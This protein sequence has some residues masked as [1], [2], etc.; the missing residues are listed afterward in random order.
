MGDLWSNPSNLLTVATFL[1]G[2]IVTFLVA[3]YSN[4]G[5]QRWVGGSQ[6]SH[7]KAEIIQSLSISLGEGTPLSKPVLLAAIRSV[8]REKQLPISDELDA[9]KVREILDELLYRVTANPF[10]ESNRR[11]NLQKDLLERMAEFDREGA[12]KEAPLIVGSGEKILMP[13]FGAKSRHP[14]SV[15]IGLAAG[16]LTLSGLASIAD[17]VV[18]KTPKFSTIRENRGLRANKIWFSATGDLVALKEAGSCLM[19]TRWNRD[20]WAESATLINFEV[21]DRPEIKEISAAN[22]AVEAERCS[23]SYRGSMPLYSVSLNGSDFVWAANGSIY[24]GS[25]SSTKRLATPSSLRLLDPNG[26]GALAYLDDVVVMLYNSGDWEVVYP[27][28]PSN[29]P[30]GGRFEGFWPILFMGQDNLVTA[31]PTTGDYALISFKRT[32]T[33]ETLVRITPSGAPLATAAI[34]PGGCVYAIEQGE[35]RTFRLCPGDRV[36]YT[37]A[38]S[39][40]NALVILPGGELLA[41]TDLGLY[42]IEKD[43]T[44]KALPNTQGAIIALAASSH[45]IAYISNYGV[46]IGEID[47]AL[48]PSENAKTYLLYASLLISLVVA[49]SVLSRPLVRFMRRKF[50]PTAL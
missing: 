27:N 10:L 9:L 14:L 18:E 40:V 36:Y 37:A 16:I 6:Y 22:K 13:R 12:T 1:I 5:L 31:S 23:Q 15:L 26:I 33:F 8:L 41:G 3:R 45:G 43:E 7:A 11:A 39:H 46:T 17:S 44:P 29:S 19:V 30:G 28:N 47:Y 4:K 21:L 48:S 32:A 25:L 34:G 50:S 49:L 2:V 35:A 24:F 38:P 42:I 20:S